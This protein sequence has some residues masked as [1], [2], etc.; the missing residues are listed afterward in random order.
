MVALSKKSSLSSCGVVVVRDS[1]ESVAFTDGVLAEDR[2]V[3]GLQPKAPTNPIKRKYER[4]RRRSGDGNI[5]SF[6]NRFEGS[7]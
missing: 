5:L 3:D 4:N 7:V 6:G 2:A 1:K